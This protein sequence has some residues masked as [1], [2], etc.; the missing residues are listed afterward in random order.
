MA[1]GAD[2]AGQATIEEA[3]L[4]TTGSLYAEISDAWRLIQSQRRE[5]P[6][7]AVVKLYSRRE[8]RIDTEI[9]ATFAGLARQWREE[10]LFSSSVT[11]IV[12]NEAYLQIIGLGSRALPL[13]LRELSKELDHWF[14]ALMSITRED[15][16]PPEDAGNMERMRQ[17]WL[18]LGEQ[19]GW[20]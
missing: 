4:R 6:T 2:D 13:I 11:D 10:T 3:T 7:K 20:I 8:V 17:A 1:P 19:R 18:E 5:V 12:S 16:V 9:E 14:V 15:P